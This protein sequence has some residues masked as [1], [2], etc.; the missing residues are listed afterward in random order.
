MEWNYSDKQE[1]NSSRQMSNAEDGVIEKNKQET[2]KSNK[3]NKKTIITLKQIEKQAKRTKKIENSYKKNQSFT[4]Y[5]RKHKSS[6][7]RK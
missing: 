2:H 6:K 3:R 4:M 7:P 5:R 1:K